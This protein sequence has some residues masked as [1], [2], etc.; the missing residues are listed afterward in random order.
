MPIFL[1]FKAFMSLLI[2]AEMVV[3]WLGDFFLLIVDG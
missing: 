2:W 1:F 3:M